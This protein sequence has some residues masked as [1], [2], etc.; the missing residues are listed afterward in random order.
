M[1]VERIILSNKAN[2]DQ[3][4]F[5]D[6]KVQSTVLNYTPL[7]TAS[8]GVLGTLLGVIVTSFVNNQRSKL[9]HKNTLELKNIEFKRTKLEELHLLFQKWEIDLQG[10]CLVFI[11]VYKGA[12]TAENAMKLS[13]ENRLQ[14][15]GDF[16]KLQTILQLHFPDL[17]EEFG[18]LIK[19]RDDVLD[20]CREN[21]SFKRPR[22]DELIKAQET[23]D[24]K[25]KEFKVLM[26]L[27]ASEL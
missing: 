11:P 16:Q 20:Y 12:N 1:I 3:E 8:L 7:I 14:E 4:I 15:K 22:L 19:L 26:A 25:A 13:T 2:I 24:N 27:Q 10:M 6:P 21:R 9:E 17:F 18:S 5:V 23:F